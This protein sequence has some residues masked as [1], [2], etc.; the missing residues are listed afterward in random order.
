MI[1]GGKGV[2]VHWP[3][4]WTEDD[5]IHAL[6]VESEV[7]KGGEEM[8]YYRQI[9]HNVNIVANVHDI[10]SWRVKIILLFKFSLVSR[11]SG[12]PNEKPKLGQD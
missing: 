5:L 7:P 6:K 10:N 12:L 1:D 8:C 4:G 2:K 9:K 11:C 3:I